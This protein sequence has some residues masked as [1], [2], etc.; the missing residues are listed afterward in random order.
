M[1]FDSFD[2]SKDRVVSADELVDFLKGSEEENVRK[3]ILRLRRREAVVSLINDEDPDP[4]ASPVVGHCNASIAV[5]G[6]ASDNMSSNVQ[7][8]V[9]EGV[10]LP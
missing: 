6:P 3:T 4:K 5:D 1:L 7:P 2:E 9:N 10:I 8:F